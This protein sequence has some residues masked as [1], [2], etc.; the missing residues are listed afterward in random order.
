MALLGDRLPQSGVQPFRSGAEIG[1]SDGVRLQ[2]I[3]TPGHSVDPVCYYLE[4]EGVLF[5]GDTILG[6][7][8]T[9][10]ND[11]G[12]Y[13]DSPQALRDLPNLQLMCPGHGPVIQDPVAYI[14]A[15][16]QG[17]HARERQILDV[18]VQTPELT[19]W[20]IME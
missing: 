9:T 1:P 15:Y 20:E 7:S 16:I 19:T 3:H 10:I 13:L 18:L 8:S 12:A 17:R 4:S 6:A 5:T 11:L 14:D 2:G